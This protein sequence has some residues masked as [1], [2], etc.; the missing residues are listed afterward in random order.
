MSSAAIPNHL[1]SMVQS[2][3]VSIVASS[4]YSMAIELPRCGIP[5][6]SQGPHCGKVPQGGLHVIGGDGVV[7]GDSNHWCPSLQVI[8]AVTSNTL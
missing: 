8:L 2:N 5:G 7:S 3:V 4:E 6:Y 1:D